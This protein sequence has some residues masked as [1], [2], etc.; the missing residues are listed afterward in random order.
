VLVACYLKQW[1]FEVFPNFLS[2]LYVFI[3]LAFSCSFNWKNIIRCKTI[4][5][6]C[7]FMV[8]RNSDALEREVCS[9][10]RL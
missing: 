5:L 1:A 7:P 4:L 10:G 2:S 6:Y 8:I 3:V 9:A